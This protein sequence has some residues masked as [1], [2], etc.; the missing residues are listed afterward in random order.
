MKRIIGIMLIGILL[1]G[2]LISQENFGEYTDLSSLEMTQKEKDKIKVFQTEKLYNNVFGFKIKKVEKAFESNK[3]KIKMKLPGDQSVTFLPIDFE[4]FSERD[5]KWFGVSEDF[6]GNASFVCKDGLIEGQVSSNGITYG[7][8]SV[9]NKSILV[10]LNNEELKNNF[11]LPPLEEDSTLTPPDTIE[12]DPNNTCVRVLVLYSEAAEDYVT[13]IDLKAEMAISQL[14][15]AINTTVEDADLTFVL[16]SCVEVDLDETWN[17]IT[18]DLNY[19]M[20]STNASSLRSTNNADLVVILSHAPNGSS[21]YYYPAG[22]FYV[23]GCVAAIGPSQQNAYALVEVAKATINYTF[24]HEVAHLFGCR[25]QI[26]SDPN[27]ANYAH[28]YGVTDGN[29]NKN[30]TIMYVDTSYTRQ[31]MFSNPDKSYNGLTMGNTTNAD[32]ARQIENT[33]STV[34]AFETDP[35]YGSL[36]CNIS[37]PSTCD[38]STSYTW[39]ASVSG[40]DTP[41]S[42][43]WYSSVDGVNYNT[44]LG[45]GSSVTTQTPSSATNFYLKLTVSSDD[46][47]TDIDFHTVYLSQ[48]NAPDSDPLDGVISSSESGIPIQ[49]QNLSLLSIFPNPAQTTSTVQ[50]SLKNDAIVK[51]ELL[52]IQGKNLKTVKKLYLNSGQNHVE[53]ITSGLQKGQYF[54]KVSSGGETHVERLII[55]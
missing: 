17:N 9:G 12:F 13:N 2:N 36:I 28:G 20:D 48:L 52:D 21:G 3:G 22:D 38:Q 34:A 46:N 10:E 19:V 27:G 5:F 18:T 26:A 54:V 37:G 6:L 32:N 25:H 40:G 41:Y 33:T 8:Y 39:T 23:S 53:L 1:S 50:I 55:D 16:T 15:T 43:L 30:S 44:Y 4:Y 29:G 49:G 45:T 42:Y 31:I 7:I 11:D 51:I 14:Q 24:A 35:Y 47:Q